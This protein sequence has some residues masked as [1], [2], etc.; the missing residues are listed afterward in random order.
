MRSLWALCL[1]SL[2]C[3]HL[4]WPRSPLLMKSHVFFCRVKVQLGKRVRDNMGRRE[5]TRWVLSSFSSQGQWFGLSVMLKFILMQQRKLTGL[6]GVLS[7]ASWLPRHSSISSSTKQGQKMHPCMRRV[8]W[9]ELPFK[10]SQA[11]LLLPATRAGENQMQKYLW[12]RSYRQCFC[13][14][15]L[16]VLIAVGY[17]SYQR[18][19]NFSWQQHQ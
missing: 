7:C 12:R 6:C 11:S 16:D 14:C 15:C 17:W 2:P 19:L 1:L 5:K 4:H 13:F 8:G 9:R 10:L 18:C 3:T